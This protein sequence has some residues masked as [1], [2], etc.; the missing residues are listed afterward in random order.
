M[1]TAQRLYRAVLLVVL[2]GFTIQQAS[3]MSRVPSRVLIQSV[4]DYMGE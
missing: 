1:S 4:S 2:E 3:E